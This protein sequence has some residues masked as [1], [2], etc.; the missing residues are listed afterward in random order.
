MVMTDLPLTGQTL[1]VAMFSCYMSICKTNGV[2]AL[3]KNTIDN[4]NFMQHEGKTPSS[5]GNRSEGTSNTSINQQN[6]IGFVG[7]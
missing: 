3:P 7:T 2:L 4:E 6:S 1:L 5:G